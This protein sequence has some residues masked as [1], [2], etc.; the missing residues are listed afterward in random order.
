MRHVLFTVGGERCGLPLQAV[1]EVVL[2]PATWTRVPRAPPVVAGVMNLRGRVVLVVR[3]QALL[4]G[5]GAGEPG[6]SARVLLLDRGRRDLGLLVGTV[7]GIEPLE[8]VAPLPGLARPGCRGLG[9]VNGAPV[10]VLDAD[11]LDAAVGALFDGAA[12]RV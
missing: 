11:A 8:K 6:P 1:R 12:R 3:L 5:A 10:T 9:Q 2:P 7:E 4:D